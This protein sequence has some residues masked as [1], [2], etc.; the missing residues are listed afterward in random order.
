MVENST[1]EYLC[2]KSNIGEHYEITD[3]QK[4]MGYSCIT[5]NYCSYY[6]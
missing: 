5:G 2:L 4:K 6:L 1:T 3:D